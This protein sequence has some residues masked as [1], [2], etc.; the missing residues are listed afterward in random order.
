MNHAIISP[1]AVRAAKA[2]ASTPEPSTGGTE[3][4][5]GSIV[6]PP[7]PL[8]QRM[9]LRGVAQVY[10]DALPTAPDIS[11]ACLTRH[12]RRQILPAW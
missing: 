9:T 8:E 3:P 10:A 2:G 12:A 5:S 1:A 7:V 11:V 4:V 6:P